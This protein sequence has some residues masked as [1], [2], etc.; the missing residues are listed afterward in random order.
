MNIAFRAAAVDSLQLWELLLFWPHPLALKTRVTIMP[1][2]LLQALEH[3]S[4]FLL[5]RVLEYRF[6]LAR[7]IFR[8][9]AQRLL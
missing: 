4:P 6:I 3:L 9:A 7:Q 2:P 8:L 5:F 1:P